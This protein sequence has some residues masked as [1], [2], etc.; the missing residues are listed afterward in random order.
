MRTELKT[1]ERCFLKVSDGY[2][3]RVM[4]GLFLLFSAF[5]NQSF[6][7]HETAGVAGDACH[8]GERPSTGR[9]RFLPVSSQ[10]G[11]W[12]LRVHPACLNQC[13]PLNRIL[14]L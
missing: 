4:P 1:R 9:S 14:W 3:Y 11:Y 10:P 7:C 5:E 13:E 12:D 8:C 2:W 6:S